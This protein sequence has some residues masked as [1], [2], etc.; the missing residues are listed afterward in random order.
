MATAE[1]WVSERDNLIEEDEGEEKRNGGREG[2][3]AGGGRR[4]RRGEGRDEWT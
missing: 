2:E 1:N 4:G 3:G